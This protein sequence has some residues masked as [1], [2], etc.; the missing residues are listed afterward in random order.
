MTENQIDNNE[1]E[2]PKLIGFIDKNNKFQSLS[3]KPKGSI[4]A[5]A[6]ETKAFLENP[7]RPRNYGWFNNPMSPKHRKRIERRL[8]KKGLSNNNNNYLINKERI[9]NNYIVTPSPSK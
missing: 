6:D 9:E 4:S 5:E 7:N 3:Q 1:Q 8:K 2:T